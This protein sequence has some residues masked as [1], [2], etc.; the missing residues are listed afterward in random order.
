VQWDLERGGSK[1]GHKVVYKQYPL[2]RAAGRR[3]RGERGVKGEE[4]GGDRS[5]KAM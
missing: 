2:A 4:G 5:M 3:R 1:A